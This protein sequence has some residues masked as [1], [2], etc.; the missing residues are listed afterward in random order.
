MALLFNLASVARLC[1][2]ST[3]HMKKLWRNNGLS[4]AFI[5]L[6]L[7]TWLVGQT[8]AGFNVYNE[9]QRDHSQ[10]Q[11]TFGQYLAT[12]HFGE[13]TAENWESEFLQMFLFVVLTSFLFQKGSAES[14]DPDKTEEVDKDPEREGSK[15]EAPWPVRKGG[16][17]LKL[18][19]YSLSLMLLALFLVS[20]VLHAAGGA[21]LYNEEQR[22][23]GN[24][25]QVTALQYVTKSQFWFESFQNWQSEF[26]SVGAMVVLSIFLR[27]K[28]SPESKS[29]DAPHS[30]TGK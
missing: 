24:T 20:F 29:V 10:P 9:D 3:L 1:M 21:Q 16:W 23:H 8:I 11:V 17:V 14:K 13:A 15:K 12:P 18:Y 26:L 5:G 25:E 2:N 27:H 19:K 4:I 30:E 28:G 22:E 6:F 7:V